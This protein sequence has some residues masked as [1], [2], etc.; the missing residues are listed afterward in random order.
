MPHG[1][2]MRG[3]RLDYLLVIGLLIVL[4]VIITLAVNPIRSLS[5]ARDSQ[6]SDDV[7]QIMTSILTL[8][9][10]KSDKYEALLRR[11]HANE[12]TKYLLGTGSSCAGD[13]GRFCPTAEIADNCLP[14]EEIFNTPEDA[15][16]DPS[17][18]L[19]GLFCT[20]YFVT[21]HDDMIEV[22]SCGADTGVIQLETFA[23]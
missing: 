14:P 1:Y 16:T 7:R 15:P 17:H 21:A 18:S 13:W 8:S 12:G 6:R 3:T 11:L 4:V 9:Q 20:G 19:F 22:G 2:F 10:Q 23:P 5:L